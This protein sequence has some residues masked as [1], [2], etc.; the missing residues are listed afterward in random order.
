[1]NEYRLQEDD[2]TILLE[3][4]TG[5]LLLEAPPEFLKIDQLATVQASNWLAKVIRKD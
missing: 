4:G 3:D 1:M 5:S 2:F